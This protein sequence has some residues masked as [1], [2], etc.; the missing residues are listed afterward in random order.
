MV[1]NDTD[2]KGGRNI[3]LGAASKGGQIRDGMHVVGRDGPRRHQRC[4]AGLRMSVVGGGW[5][6]GVDAWRTRVGLRR[7]WVFVQRRDVTY[8]WVWSPLNRI[9]STVRERLG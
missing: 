2:N 6:Q 4:V 3:A 8:G 5:V 9:W 1:G 7:V